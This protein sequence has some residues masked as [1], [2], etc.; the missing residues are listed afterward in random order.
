MDEQWRCPDCRAVLA[1]LPTAYGRRA[2]CEP[3][4]VRWTWIRGELGWVREAR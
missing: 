1:V 3:C 4:G 2:V